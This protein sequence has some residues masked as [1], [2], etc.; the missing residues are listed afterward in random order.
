[1]KGFATYL[2]AGLGRIRSISLKWKLVIPFL[3]FAFMG[4]TTIVYMGLSSQQN[5]IKDQ[6]KKEIL[7]HYRHF[8]EEIR[9][10]EIQVR[11]LATMVSQNP[12][13]QRLFA[14]GNRQALLDYLMPTYESLHRDF[15]IGYFHFHTPPAT[16]YLR[17]HRPGQS[18]E[19]MSSFRKTIADALKEGRPVA[20]LEMGVLGLGIR[21]VA[22]V[23]H[24]GG[25]IGTV[26]VGGSFG[27]VFLRSLHDIWGIDLALYELRGGQPLIS[28]AKGGE[29]FKTLYPIDVTSMITSQEPK[30]LIAPDTH[31]NKSILFGP[32]VDYAGR[33]I[34]ILEIRL[35]REETQRRLSRTR[36]IMFLIG[37]SGIAIS[38][39]LTFLVANFFIKPIKEIVEEAKN[40]AQ[41]KREHRLESGS[42]DEIGMLTQALNIMLEALRERRKEIED[43]AKDLE[44]R[45]QERTAD[46]VVSM[47]NYRT[48]VEHVPLIVYRLLQDGTTEFINSYLTESLGY[49]IEE[50]VGDRAFWREKL[51]GNMPDAYHDLMDRCFNMGEE[52]R[53]ER[54]ISHKKG[55]PLTFVDHA[56]PSKDE[57][58]R[59]RWIDG[60]MLDITQIK[61]LQ[62]RALRTEEIRI[63]GEI[64]A[65]LAHEI[66]NPLTTAGGFARRLRDATPEGHP[67]RKLAQIIVEEVVRL[68]NFLKILL[69]SIGP[70][71]LSWELVDVNKLL[72]S[73]IDSLDDAIRAKEIRV[74]EDISPD[75]PKIYGD[76]ERL[77]QAL[78]N[79]LKHAILSIPAGETLFLSTG[80]SG[81]NVLVTIRHK[82][83]HLTDDDLDQ[84]FFPHMEANPDWDVLDLPLSKII[85]H[86]HGGNVDVSREGGK[87]VAIK[88][89]FPTMHPLYHWK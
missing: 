39:F 70:F 1:M 36:D 14:E 4:T 12:D 50:A 22:P 45:V 58:G 16:S 44:K 72:L 56:I 79:I 2:L 43:Y 40:I 69:S 35:D 49:S 88:I 71:E 64:S 57:S 38:F 89:E 66:R 15:D 65:R 81:K 52:Y 87:E 23:S 10:K 63:L 59:V 34:V 77:N 53:T 62:E 31:P 11:S 83:E 27:E 29:D 85:I 33:V 26:E 55:Y 8:L 24:K 9:Q 7:H 84:F 54:V 37:A 82:L 60:I 42:T 46:L 86:K 3:F 80:L 21:G 68:E 5:L 51:Y 47:E 76:E 17:L 41:E 32:V 61:R 18:G 67:Q 19:E 48:L 28:V 74:A 20:G 13:V 78:E 25:I 30:I 75:L 6:E 73:W